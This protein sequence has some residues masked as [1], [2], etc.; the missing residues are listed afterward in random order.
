V[1]P[2]LPLSAVE[3][4][5]RS[6]FAQ[7][8]DRAVSTLQTCAEPDPGPVLVLG[9]GDL[10]TSMGRVGRAIL[11]FRVAALIRWTLLGKRV[12]VAHT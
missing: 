12:I 5:H 4:T 6:A 7:K 8:L 10:A 11:L 2:R 3:R 9:L 1:N